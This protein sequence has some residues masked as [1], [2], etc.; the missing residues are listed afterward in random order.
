MLNTSVPPMMA[1]TPSPPPSFSMACSS[2]APVGF[3][4]SELGWSGSAAVDATCRVTTMRFLRA[5]RGPPSWEWRPCTMTAASSR[6]AWKKCWSAALRMESGITPLASAIMPSAET[7]TKPSMLRK[8][9]APRLEYCEVFQQRDDAE[10]DDHHAHDLLGAAV[11]RQHVDQIKDEDDDD[12]G[13]QCADENV[14]GI[15]RVKGYAKKPP[16]PPPIRVTIVSTLDLLSHDAA[17]EAPT[18]TE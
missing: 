15:L 9:T 14:H 12:K 13:D 17:R 6:P 18:R 10:H 8:A 4:S 1:T 11:H 7:M 5:A 16:R 2:V 3:Q